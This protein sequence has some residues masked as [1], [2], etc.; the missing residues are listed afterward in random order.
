MYR[1]VSPVMYPSE[2]EGVGEVRKR[3]VLNAPIA[4]GVG[5]VP[6]VPRDARSA[7]FYAHVRPPPS[8]YS[9]ADRN[10]PVEPAGQEAV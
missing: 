6:G 10:R 1:K 9:A 4:T 3:S 5:N 8:C 7:T 2:G